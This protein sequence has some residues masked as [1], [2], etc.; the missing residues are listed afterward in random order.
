MSRSTFI[1][2]PVPAASPAKCATGAGSDMVISTRFGVCGEL[3][4]VARRVLNWKKASTLEGDTQNKMKKQCLQE[5]VTI[6]MRHD[7]YIIPTLAA[8]E[9]GLVN[10]ST[11]R[12]H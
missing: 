9:N 10:I 1:S 5:L 2:M 12:R 11:P 3:H 7:D 4:S 6:L 8:L